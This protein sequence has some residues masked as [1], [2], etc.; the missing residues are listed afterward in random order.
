M[1]NRVLSKT[2]IGRKA[3]EFYA[4]ALKAKLEPE[5]IGRV[6]VVDVTSDDYQIGDSILS[7]TKPLRERRPN[8]AFFALRIG[9]DAMYSLTGANSP[10]TR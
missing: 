6:V 10:R 3:E 5:H 9:S 1:A 2:D 4:R 8:G 7:A